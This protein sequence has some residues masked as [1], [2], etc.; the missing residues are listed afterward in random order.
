MTKTHH[1]P[2]APYQ[3]TPEQAQR[4][5]ARWVHD[6][7]SRLNDPIPDAKIMMGGGRMGNGCQVCMGDLRVLAGLPLRGQ[8]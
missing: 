6:V 7:E 4:Q 2:F 3:T 8:Q 5:L 1:K